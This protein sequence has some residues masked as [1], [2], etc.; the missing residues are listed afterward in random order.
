[1]GNAD[2]NGSW[3]QYY[4]HTHRVVLYDGEKVM[5][6]KIK[7]ADGSTA[8]T[9]KIQDLQKQRNQKNLELLQYKTALKV[10]YLALIKQTGSTGQAEQEIANDPTVKKLSSEL[11]SLDKQLREIQTERDLNLKGILDKIGGTDISSIISSIK[12]DLKDNELSQ[13]NLSFSDIKGEIFGSLVIGDYISVELGW[14]NASNPRFQLQPVFTGIVTEKQFGLGPSLC[15]VICNDEKVLLAG[16]NKTEAIGDNEISDDDD[17]TKRFA[18][19]GLSL[20]AQG[21]GKKSEKIQLNENDLSFIIR[22]AKANGQNLTII[23]P[24]PPPQ[25]GLLPRSIR[26]KMYIYALG[27]NIIN[28]SISERYVQASEKEGQHSSDE[29]LGPA[30]PPI[31]TSSTKDDM[32]Q[33]S[34]V[35]SPANEPVETGGSTDQSGPQPTKE[36]NPP[37][38]VPAAPLGNDPNEFRTLS[39]RLQKEQQIRSTL[40]T[41]REVSCDLTIPG[42]P[43]INNMSQ[44][45]VINICK[46]INMF[47]DTISVCHDYGPDRYTTQITGEPVG[48]PEK[49]DIGELLKLY[50]KSTKTETALPNQPI[51][52]DSEQPSEL[53][54]TDGIPRVWDIS[55]YGRPDAY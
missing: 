37:G 47:Y 49:I 10:K 27:E 2:S 50:D 33:N 44:F 1:M 38:S 34:P 45:Y 12:V 54:E 5:A 13:C 32:E 28:F 43:S 23:D 55:R 51:L 19:Q 24:G 26:D 30:M 52:K 25:Y 53:R 31:S 35:V 40:L 39:E 4:Y 16:E 8:D 17:A 11:A 7:L 9:A 20:V 29:D 36:P 21:G 18:S 42:E 14:L 15:N 3:E 41:N 22:T 6:E 46:Y 48:L